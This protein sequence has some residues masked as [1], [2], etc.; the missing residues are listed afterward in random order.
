MG[1][2]V[3]AVPVLLIVGGVAADLLGPE[4][5]TGLPLL[6]AA[7]LTACMVFPFR[8]AAFTAVA[9]CVASVAV[10][11]LVG[12][13]APALLVDLLDV[14]LIGGI[15]LWLNRAVH[16]QSR[17]LAVVQDIAEA[18][19]RAVLPSPPPRLGS[20]SIACRYEC[21]HAEALI[22][23]DFYAVQATPYGVRA[24]VGDV[25]GK[26]LP[27]VSTMAAVVGAFRE[28]AVQAPTLE[29]LARRLDGVLE[30]FTADGDEGPDALESFATAVFVQIPD[31]GGVLHLLSRGHPAPYLI[32]DGRVTCLEPTSSRLPLGMGLPEGDGPE[33]CDTFPF[34][35]GC[36]V[37]L[38]TDGVTEAR[39]RYGVF[40]DPRIGLAHRTFPQSRDLVDTLASEVAAWTGGRQQDDMA[41]LALCPT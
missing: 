12:R 28:A 38:V 23:G 33:T 3:G 14:A 20:L 17:R 37:L 29:E 7:P 1:P 26:G 8:T 9:V 36:C 39:N 22:G 34:D 4:P 16:R 41:I 21:A 2:L 10:D 5:Y 18:T 25:R 35:P 6:A 19:Q 32:R 13:P 15:A 40:Y 24:V 11:L 31:E 27:A 30:R